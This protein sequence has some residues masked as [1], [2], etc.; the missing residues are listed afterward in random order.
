MISKGDTQERETQK[1]VKNGGFSF[2][3]TEIKKI[4]NIK[5]KSVLQWHMKKP[6]LYKIKFRNRPKNLW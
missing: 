5:I 3:F 2:D 4:L 6:E 1:K